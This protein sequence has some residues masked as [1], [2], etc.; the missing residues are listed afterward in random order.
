MTLH[1]YSP[2][3][4]KYVRQ[5]FCNALPQSS[6]LR[7]WYNTINC[8]PGWFTSESFDALK[9]RVLEE[10]K[11]GKQVIVALMLDEMGIKKGIQYLREGKLRGY[12]DI[13]SEIETCNDILLAKDALVFMA[14]A[15][16]DRWKIPLGYFLV[17]GID[18]SASAGLIR[19]CLQRLDEAKHC[20]SK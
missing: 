9:K 7:S 20:M 19:D 15:L 2:K 13:G 18:A 3:A 6:T 10:K 4:Y 17:N 12:I 8:E 5:K 14:V 1:F 11:I 16:D